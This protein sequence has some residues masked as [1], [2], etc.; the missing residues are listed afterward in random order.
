S[1]SHA[2]LIECLALAPATATAQRVRL[3]TACA[4]V[5]HLLGRH[6]EAHLRLLGA[7]DDLEDECSAEGVALMIEL[8]VDGFYRLEFEPM[9]GWAER[10]LSAARPLG[11]PPL[12]AAALALLAY[13]ATLGGAMAEAENNRSE[14][15]ALVDALS[16]GD[17][18]LRL[19][20][21]VNLA[22]A[23]LDLERFAEAEAHAER[24]M[25]VGEAT[26]QSDIVP[27]LVYCL[28]W[29]RRR[30]G[31]LASSAELLDD[32][33]ESARLSGNDHSLVGNLLNQSLTALAVGD[34]ELARSAAAE[35]VDLS[36]RFDKGLVSASASHSL[37]SALLEDGAAAEAVE[38]LIG[39][40]GGVDFPL[41]PNAWRTHF[42]ELLTRCWLELGRI[43]EA[44]QAADAA[45]MCAEAFGLR[46]AA[47][48][49]DRAAAAVALASKKPG[50]A[51]ERALES[52]TVADAV[53]VPI[54]AA[55]GRMLAGRALAQDGQNERAAAELTRAAEVFDSSGALRYRDQAERQLRQLGHHIHRRTR[56]GKSDGVGVELLTE[57]QLQIARLVVA[58]RTNP[59]IAA[60]LF[61]SQ[62]T[63]ESHMHNM[64][65]KVGVSSR[66]DLA[67]AVERADRTTGSGP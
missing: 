67:R 41:I 49:A 19:D 10:A 59:Q 1:E 56:A 43:N 6:R 16:D 33:V 31:E 38:A 30:R 51:A 39:A 48:L 44:G 61:L 18:A 25:T 45:A 60:E 58:R 28:A 24:A 22:A 35:S 57:R 11:S 7:L 62:K 21:A 8:A 26:G 63:V 52:A 32:A 40:A 36:A 53:G 2:A 37:A 5:E 3:I 47:A 20:A 65:H 27:I 12:T 66:V 29:V 54:E 64:F 55:L 14:A 46:L 34:I 9:R 15:A 4:G 23:E 50:I 17:L 42:L 13:A